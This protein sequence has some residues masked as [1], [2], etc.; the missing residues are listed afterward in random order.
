MGIIKKNVNERSLAN[1][2]PKA[3]YLGKERFNITLMPETIEWLKSG[4][5]ASQRIEDLVRAAKAKEIRYQETNLEDTHNQNKVLKREN[6]EL[7]EKLEKLQSKLDYA[8]QEIKKIVDKAEL[9]ESGFKSN[10]FG[11][12][13]KLIKEIYNSLNAHE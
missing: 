4:G 9:K 11:Q 10:A 7:I 8:N 13:I 5:N 1:L 12:G 2:N 6:Q 3:R